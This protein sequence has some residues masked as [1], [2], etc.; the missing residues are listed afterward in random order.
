MVVGYQPARVRISVAAAAVVA[1]Q[2]PGGE[3]LVTL[4][5]PNFLLEGGTL[6]IPADIP[7]A[8]PTRSRLQTIRASLERAAT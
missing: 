2:L 4:Y 3:Q 1:S 8:I 7:P 6:D 5:A